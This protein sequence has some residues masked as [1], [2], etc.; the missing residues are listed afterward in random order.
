MKRR[1]LTKSRFKLASECPTKLFYDGKP[2]YANQKLQDD[3]LEAL[4]EAV[5]KLGSWR[6]SISRADII[7][8]HLIMRKHY[9]KRKIC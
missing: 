9:A 4:A 5:F 2:E 1:Y 6:S 7:L 8:I 3:F